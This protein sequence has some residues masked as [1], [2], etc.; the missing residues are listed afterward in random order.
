MNDDTELISQLSWLHQRLSDKLDAAREKRATA[1]RTARN[2]RFEITM[3][4]DECAE[5]HTIILSLRM[6]NDLSKGVAK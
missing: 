2:L 3:L 5:L 1:N 6:K 4:Q